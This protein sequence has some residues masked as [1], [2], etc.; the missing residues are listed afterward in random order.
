MIRLLNPRYPVSVALWALLVAAVAVL[1]L[2]GAWRWWALVP[3]CVPFLIVGRGAVLALRAASRRL[4]QLDQLGPVTGPLPVPAAPGAGSMD[5]DA[6][7][8]A[9]AYDPR[10]GLGGAASGA[11]DPQTG[12]SWNG[13]PWQGVAAGHAVGCL[14]PGR[15]HS[16]CPMLA[17]EDTAP[18]A[19]LDDFVR[20]LQLHGPRVD[21]AV[22]AEPGALAELPGAEPITAVVRRLDPAAWAPFMTPDE[23]AAV[24]GPMGD[25]CSICGSVAVPVYVAGAYMGTRPACE[26]Q[27]TAEVEQAAAP[28]PSRMADTGELRAVGLPPRNPTEKR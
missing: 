6:D 16:V 2:P 5:L 25:D 3:A 28:E 22:D 11:V 27:T 7:R 26:H 1:V 14:Q 18:G 17:P 19:W 23:F 10:Y 24:F 8:A 15:P 13:E 21:K 9:G 4:D 12:A 20:L